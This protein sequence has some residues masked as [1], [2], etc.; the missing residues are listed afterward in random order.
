MSALSK[1]GRATQ[2]RVTRLL[3]DELG[4]RHLG[5]CCPCGTKNGTADRAHPKAEWLQRHHSTV[6]DF[7]RFL[8]L[9]TSVPRAHA[10]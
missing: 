5:D 6:T 8:G 1:P 2:V 3:C 9:S 7:A 4:Y 10:V